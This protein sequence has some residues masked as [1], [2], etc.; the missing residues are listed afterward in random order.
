LERV[1]DVLKSMH[2]WRAALEHY[3]ESRTIRESL[4][5]SEQDSHARKADLAIIY[6]SIADALGK[7]P[8]GDLAQAHQLIEKAMAIF[9]QPGS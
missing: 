4:V 7:Q 1:G 6:G 3:R 9:Q 8:N 5:E 2:Q